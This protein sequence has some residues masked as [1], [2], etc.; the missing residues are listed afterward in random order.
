MTARLMPCGRRCELQAWISSRRISIR[1][2]FFRVMMALIPNWD[3][4][5]DNTSVYREACGE[6]SDAS[7]LYVIQSFRTDE[8]RI[9][10]PPKGGI[11]AYRVADRI[12]IMT[13]PCLGTSVEKRL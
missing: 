1:N 3:L 8:A 10:W 12:S 13:T 4:T 2:E 9:R 11:A 7:R 6:G 5:D